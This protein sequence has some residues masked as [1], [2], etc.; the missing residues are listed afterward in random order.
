MKP[1]V[2]DALS[3]SIMQIKFSVDFKV[4]LVTSLVPTHVGPHY[5]GTPPWEHP[6]YKDT[7]WLCCGSQLYNNNCVQNYPWNVDTS[8]IRTLS[9]V[10]TIERFHC[11]HLNLLHI[12]SV[13]RK[14]LTK[15]HMVK[16]RDTFTVGGSA[17]LH[18]GWKVLYGIP[19]VW[20]ML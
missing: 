16:G 15:S 7:S 5:S 19:W 13:L 12:T 2:I 20:G 4:T 14:Q 6:L 1:C 17:F 8:L 9:A 3:R 11:I 18:L 10:P